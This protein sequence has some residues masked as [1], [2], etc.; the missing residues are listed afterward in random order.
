MALAYDRRVRLAYLLR[1]RIEGLPHLYSRSWGVM[2]SYSGV[3]LELWALSGTR[4]DM[5]ASKSSPSG[6]MCVLE[7]GH[8]VRA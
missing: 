2:H 5:H 8:P 6:L 4:V 3:P 1:W 7:T